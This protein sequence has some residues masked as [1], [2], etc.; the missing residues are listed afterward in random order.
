MGLIAVFQ[1]LVMTPP[2][3]SSSPTLSRRPIS[4]FKKIK[5]V[6][7]S[8][9]AWIGVVWLLALLIALPI[10]VI[11]GQI[12]TN[13]STTWQHLAETVLKD[14]VLNSC[15]LM[16][17]VGLGVTVIGVG[18]AWLVTM[19]E[20]WGSRA[21]S[22][23]LLLPF[24][25]PAY[26]LAYTYTVFLSFEGPVQS[27]LRAWTGWEWGDYWFPEIRSLPGAI[28]M[29]TLVL[30]PYV[31]LLARVAFLEQATCTLE[32]SRSLGCGPWRSFWTVALPLARPAIAAGV[33][34]A[35]MET[36]NDFGTVQYFGVDTFTTGI[37]RTWLG[38]GDR[39]GAAQLA[40]VLLLFIFGLLL[41][42]RWSRGQARFTKQGHSDQLRPYSLKTWRAGLAT[43][44]CFLP[45]G[46]G[47]MA[48]ATVLLQMAIREG[49]GA[50]NEEFWT[51]AGHSLIL[52]GLAALLAVILGVFLAYGLRLFPAWS[53][54]LGTQ[55]AVMGYAIPGA[56]IAVGILV[57]LGWVDNQM[58]RFA[59]ATFNISTG[60]VLSGTIFALLYA[61]LVRFLAVSFNSVEASLLKI[62]PSLDEAA[63]SLGKTVVGTLI[64][65]HLPLMTT[66]LLT[67]A[68]MVFVDV[69]KELPATL[70]IRPFNFDTLAIQVYRLA[71]D[72]RLNEAAG[73]A[74]AIVLVGL[75]PVLWLSWQIHRA[76]QQHVTK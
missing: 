31:Y 46:L 47:F 34:L 64:S 32:A 45:V 59:V 58:D 51:H 2:L 9:Q 19:C 20:F 5:Q 33:A 4:L 27:G 42:E 6:L 38:L 71:S 61:Y 11:L 72:E 73:G 69:M 7:F 36:L 25:A 67:A 21:W 65:V 56:V 66:G 53:L 13:S 63:R 76:G 29:L 75:I 23:L 49:A 62:R 41:A 28:L 3:T 52:S 24:A 16:L 14:Y 18:T 74:L 35:L 15:W 50:W 43:L 30:Y 60:L 48:P 70:V 26:I 40:S 1:A 22:W 37:Y 55:L 54:R 8:A 57:P 68:M 12:L 39:T 44:F 10:L 17:G